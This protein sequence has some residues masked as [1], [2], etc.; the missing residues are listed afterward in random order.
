M[1][2]LKD[3]LDALSKHWRQWTKSLALP[4]VVLA[5][6]VAA[7]V[8]IALKTSHDMFFPMW[9]IW[10]ATDRWDFATALIP[11]SMLWLGLLAVAVS[12]MVAAMWWAHIRM[13]HTVSAYPERD[14][15]GKAFVVPALICGSL[16]TVVVLVMWLPTAVLFFSADAAANA[17]LLEDPVTTPLWVWPACFLSAFVATLVC[18][19]AVTLARLVFHNVP[20]DTP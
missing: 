17:I 8:T 2:Y 3:T 14:V 1:K 18:E 9:E 6:A 5:M 4:Y 10:R 12:T 20:K 11:V 7:V 15:K 19:I 16:L 13:H